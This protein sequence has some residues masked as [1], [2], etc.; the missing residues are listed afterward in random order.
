MV[1]R[2]SGRHRRTLDLGG[3]RGGVPIR[4][5]WGQGGGESA[6]RAWL[7]ARAVACRGWLR[8]LAGRSDEAAADL[9]LTQEL[10]DRAELCEG[11]PTV[12][13][14]ERLRAQLCCEG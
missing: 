6:R 7:Q 11:S 4:R 12:P 5:A 14:V 2:R 13:A 3:T 8:A 9:I 10:V 1:A